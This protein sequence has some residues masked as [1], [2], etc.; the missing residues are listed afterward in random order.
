MWTPPETQKNVYDRRPRFLRYPSDLTETRN[1]AHLSRIVN[2]DRQPGGKNEKRTVD[3][4]GEVMERVHVCS[5]STGRFVKWGAAL[6]K[7]TYAPKEAR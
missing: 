1:G 5:W 4:S 3:L 2:P 6:A 7:G